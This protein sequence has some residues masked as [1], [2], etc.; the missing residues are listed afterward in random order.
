MELMIISGMSGAGKT[1]TVNALED[2]GFYCIDN[3]PPKIIPMFTALCRDSDK[4]DIQRVAMVVDVRSRKMFADL[5]HVLAELKQ[6]GLN[7]R[8]LFLDASTEVLIQRFKETRRRHPLM[9]DAATPTLGQAIEIEREMLQPLRAAAD[10][11]IDT[12]KIRP[13]QLR[14]RVVNLIFAKGA[15]P[16]MP[17]NVISFG[18]KNGLPPEADLVFDVRCLPNPFYLPDL[19]E[20]T[21]SEACV[22]DYVMQFPQTQTMLEKLKDLLSFLVPLYLQEGKTQLVVAIGCTGGRHRSV[23]VA[24]YLSAYLSE[25]SYNA[26]VTHRDKEKDKLY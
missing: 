6:S 2:A 14:E 4:M 7:Y 21:G 8:V 12:A 1:K 18:F 15:G 25:Q 3:I 9:D 5:D 11:V 22:R 20:H 26:S 23:T 16:V 19:R 13:S 10:Y 24:E 17:I